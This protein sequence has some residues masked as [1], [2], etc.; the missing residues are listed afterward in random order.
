MGYPDKTSLYQYQFGDDP[1]QTI[2]QSDIYPP[3]VWA[4]QVDFPN[5][6]MDAFVNKTDTVY[7][8]GVPIGSCTT[9]LVG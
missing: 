7:H 2:P 6:T 3:R 9:K 5:I 8:N 1:V 4:F